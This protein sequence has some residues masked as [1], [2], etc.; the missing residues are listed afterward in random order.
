MPSCR[1]GPPLRP[2]DLLPCAADR[3]A[4]S[5]ALVTA[6]AVLTYGELERLSRR[7]A[8]ALRRRGIGPGD[9]VSLIGQNG[10]EWIVAYHGVL[11]CGAIVNPINVMLSAPELAHVLNDCGSR[12]LIA[13]AEQT[14]VAAAALAL[15]PGVALHAEYGGDGTS[16]AI[17]MEVLLEDGTRSPLTRV[18][19]AEDG[20]CAIV[21]TSGT[22]GHPKGAMQSHRAVLLNWALTATMHARTAADTLVTALPAA[23]VYG[24]VAINSIF[25]VGGEVVLMRRFEAR[26]ALNLIAA[27]RAT[28]FEGVPAMYAMMLADNAL[29]GADLNS[30]RVATVGGQTLPADMVEAW[31]RE[32]GVP[33]IQLWGMT[34]IAG[35]GATHSPWCPAD[36]NSVGVALPGVDVRIAALD[37][38][39]NELPAGERGELQIRGPIVMLGYVGQPE[40]SRA[41]LDDDGWL[42]T[43]DIAYQDRGGCV[44]V[45]D[46][47]KDMII[48]GGYNVYP[49]EIERVLAAHP[50]VSQVA[51]VGRPDPVRGEIAVAYVVAKPG[52]MP[53][54]ESIIDFCRGSLAAYK[55]PR[56][57]MFVAGLPMTSSGKI[58]RRNLEEL[59]TA[60]DRDSA[61]DNP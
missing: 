58:S 29:G 39:R 22:T 60:R 8:A 28:M 61:K 32:T 59:A 34:E 17:P 43:G 2:A 26:E 56:E 48:T 21:Y 35:L 12:A 24:N 7:L 3:D 16:A 14:E 45:V 9:V 37:G 20:L 10:W 25:L 41:A 4:D 53:T 27:R 57:V 44:Y 23:H 52:S 1:F 49:A 13:S 46:R 50:Q 54:A 18:V 33:M 15:A 31:R 47:A 42:R 40:A 36:P 5:V 30:L 11:R 38:S 55:R 6:T 19:S 51:V